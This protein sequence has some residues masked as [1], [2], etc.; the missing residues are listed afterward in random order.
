MSMSE[1]ERENIIPSR[2]QEKYVNLSRPFYHEKSV[3]QDT[4]NLKDIILYSAV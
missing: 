3:Y 2:M 1:N 4:I